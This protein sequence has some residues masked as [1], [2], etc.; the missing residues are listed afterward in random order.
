MI[1]YNDFKIHW[2]HKLPLKN[3]SNNE[4]VRGETVCF[5]TRKHDNSFLLVG[6]AY[7]AEEDQ[8]V[9]E[10]GRKISLSRA[11][12][13]SSFTKDERAKIW[14]CYLNRKK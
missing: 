12:E 3:P 10:I 1:F 11:L 9:K 7:L 14:E 2:L 8:Y 6:T 13:H 4:T 5:I